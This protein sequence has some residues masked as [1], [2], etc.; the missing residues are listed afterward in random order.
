MSTTITTEQV[1]ELRDKTGVSVMQCRKALEEAGGDM[2]KATVILRKKGSEVAEK[3]A[4]RAAADGR[5]VI[6]AENGKAVVLTLNC[7][8]DF[9]AQ[10]EDFKTLAENIMSIAWNEGVEAAKSQAPALIN[11]VVLKI[12]ENIQL[13]S[14]EEITGDV[15]GTYT[16][17]NG[18][19]GAVVALSGGSVEVAKDVAMHAAAM[20][21]RYMSASEITDKERAEATEVLE[22]E[23]ANSDKPEEIKAKMLEGKLK[24][25]FSEQT[26]TGQAFF[27]D[28]NLTIEQYLANNKATLQ[29]AHIYTI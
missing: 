6:K 13:G 10:N 21:P 5:I 25:Y 3:K 16:H 9:V 29:S 1:K 15:I 4:D 12:G 8:T 2:E 24:T 28:P 23:V 27:K 20:K 11:D 22:K 18:K 14:I 7:E 17:Y 26:L 19:N